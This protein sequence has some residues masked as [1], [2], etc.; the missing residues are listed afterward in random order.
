FKLPGLRIGGVSYVGPTFNDTESIGFKILACL[1]AMADGSIKNG[2]S[3]PALNALIKAYSGDGAIMKDLRNTVSAIKTRVG[4]NLEI[5]N[6]GPISAAYPEAKV[7]AAFYGLHKIGI[8]RNNPW[9]DPYYRQ[10]LVNKL[11]HRLDLG[12]MDTFIAWKTFREVVGQFGYSPSTAFAI[13]LLMN[14]VQVLS[15]DPFV[16]RFTDDTHITQNTLFH[17]GDG[18]PAIVIRTILAHD[19]EKTREA[20]AIIRVVWEQR[21]AAYA[22]KVGNVWDDPYSNGAK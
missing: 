22:R 15:I 9:S 8:D 4:R 10:W 14:G 7:E 16:P 3:I 21:T 19:E 2:I 1:R 18:S 13:E 6:F 5:L 20:A 11:Q 12:N 17:N